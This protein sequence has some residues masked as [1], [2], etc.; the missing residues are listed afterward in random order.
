VGT[1][2]VPFGG[3]PADAVA[4]FVTAARARGVGWLNA[5]H[6]ST[7]MAR[8]CALKPCFKPLDV[9]PLRLP[10]EGVET[11]EVAFNQEPAEAVVGML[12][13]RGFNSAKVSRGGVSSRRMYFLFFSVHFFLCRKTTVYLWI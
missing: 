1:L 7:V 11:L 3:E 6:A 5:S 9:R 10:V 13:D 2:E 12:S 4:A 8:L